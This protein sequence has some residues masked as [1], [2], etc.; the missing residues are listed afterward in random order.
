MN[1]QGAKIAKREF[2]GFFTLPK[3]LGVLWRLGGSTLRDYGHMH[4]YTVSAY[5]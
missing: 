5:G 4:L 1:R 2:I 3:K